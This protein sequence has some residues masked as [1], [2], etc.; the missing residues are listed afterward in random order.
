MTTIFQLK[1]ALFAD[2]FTLVRLIGKCF[3]DHGIAGCFCQLA[4]TVQ[5]M[6]RRYSTNKDVRCE[7]GDPFKYLLSQLDSLIVKWAEHAVNTPMRNVNRVFNIAHNIIGAIPKDPIPY[8]CL[9]TRHEPFRCRDT[10]GDGAIGHLISDC[11]DQEDLTKLCFYERVKQICGSA[12]TSF[13][14]SDSRLG[15]W[16]GL[17]SRGYEDLDSLEKEFAAAFSDSYDEV[18]DPL[19]VKLLE[20]VEATENDEQYQ[21]A[22]DARKNIC[23][24]NA[25]ASAMTLGAHALMRF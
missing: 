25:F 5:P 22:I 16:M 6:W 1:D 18:L 20:A 23:S 4:L 8:V 10:Y 17:F 12:T 11:E 21:E 3:G 24:T 15:D 19:L 14:E 13:G 2:F 9:P 7:N